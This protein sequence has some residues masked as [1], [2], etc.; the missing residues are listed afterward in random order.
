V[1]SDNH[2]VA[3]G[4]PIFIHAL[5]HNAA[6]VGQ[7]KFDVAVGEQAIGQ[8]FEKVT[9]GRGDRA[10]VFH[11]VVLQV[12]GDVSIVWD[13]FTVS[14]AFAGEFVTVCNSGRC[15]RVVDSVKTRAWSTIQAPA[16]AG[17]RGFVDIVDYENYS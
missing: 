2:A 15:G 12:V 11:T 8:L 16:Y 3:V 4:T 9:I 5:P 17:L 7:I 1:R 13:S 14:S 10:F 6:H